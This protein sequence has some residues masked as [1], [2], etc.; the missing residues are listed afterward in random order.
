MKIT[1]AY[2]DDENLGLQYLSSVLKQHG[3]Q[4]ELVFDPAL[5]DDCQ[6]QAG[7]LHRLFSFEE[8]VVEDIIASGPALI[9]FSLLTDNYPWFKRI[10]KA[11]KEQTDIPIV[12][13]GI[14]ATSVPD[15]VIREPFVDY[16]ITGEGEYPLLALVEHLEG[17]RPVEE[18][19]SLWYKSGEQ[20]RRTTAL[21]KIAD[22]DDI[23]Y[24]DKDLFYEK[25]PMY[26][27][28]YFMEASRGCAYKCTFC[29]HSVDKDE[30]QTKRSYRT[31]S[32]PH[33]IDELVKAKQ[34]YKMHSVYF[35]DE[36]FGL[37]IDWLREFS[38]EYREKVAVPFSC[39]MYPST[40]DEEKGRLLRDASCF[41]VEMGVQ[42][43][44]TDMKRKLNRFETNGRV[45]QAIAIL[46]EN[47]IKVHAQNIIALPGEREEHLKEML[48]FYSRVKPD[49]AFFFWL[50]Y[51]PR[52][53]VIKDA[54]AEGIMTPE[55]VK[56][57]EDGHFPGTLNT[58][59]TFSNRFADRYYLLL[60]LA[61]Y[62]PHRFVKYIIAK[63]LIHRFPN[64]PLRR[65]NNIIIFFTQRFDELLPS[66]YGSKIYRFNRA[67]G[68]YSH[69]TWKK[70]FGRRRK[71]TPPPDPVGLDPACPPR[72]S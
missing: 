13:G 72:A 56:L 18:V 48:E 63:D 12:V 7:F 15:V 20:V 8:Q 2:A 24:P 10:A 57:I 50:R 58:G 47:G 43:I 68:R 52:T 16:L 33:V 31:R 61:K 44:N 36:L 41:M 28:I 55:Q 1:F 6:I 46:Q 42:S 60:N 26:R 38:R 4:T 69:F 67:V 62:L 37:D 51:Y 66:R 30:P 11:I 45:E 65:I 29:H 71:K 49:V 53:A 9:G 35:T 70:I 17:R 39:S 23:P 27:H 21:P 3:H 64:L 54:L 34:K 40:I 59:G 19:P 25:A 22:L 5:F 32:V 14:H